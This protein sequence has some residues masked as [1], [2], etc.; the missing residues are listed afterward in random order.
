MLNKI[1]IVEDDAT[2][3]SLIGKY[4][5]DF[6][7]EISGKA[8][9][10]ESAIKSVNDTNPDLILMDIQ[11]E[12]VIDGID[13]AIK[14]NDNFDIPI[15]FITSS[16]DTETVERVAKIN[17][18]GY[19]IKPIDKN[20]LKVSMQMAFLRHKMNKEIKEN[21]HRFS[22]ILDCMVDAVFVT[23]YDGYLTYANS[24]AKSILRKND[25]EIL[26]RLLLDVVAIEKGSYE[27]IENCSYIIS[28]EGEKIP[29]DYTASPVKDEKGNIFGTVL[30]LR[31]ISERIKIELKL[32]ESLEN[33]RKTMGGVISAMTMT[34]ESR[35]PY[36]AGHQKRVSSLAR[37]IAQEMNLPSNIIESIRM[38]GTIH[39][40][41]KISI[42]AEILSKPGKLTDIEF[43]LDRK[44]VV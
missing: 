37:I 20:D 9:D 21:Q 42:P 39:D 41:G 40:L 33:M 23:D 30:V 35:D 5:I 16:T 11:L 29:L 38:A 15:I 25:S 34:V 2:T 1:L 27:Q 44:S 7:F 28:A 26:N 4:I 43:S 12:G 22:T 6:G 3:L 19:I 24:K 32:K 14:I 36:T 13:A 17:S 31:D 10:G 18:Y 8:S